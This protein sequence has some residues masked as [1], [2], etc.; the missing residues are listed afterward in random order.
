MAICDAKY[1]FTLVDVEACGRQSDGGIFKRSAMGKKFEKKSMNVPDSDILGNEFLPYVLVADEAFEMN[2]FTMRPYSR[3]T[4]NNERRIFNY[5]LSRARRVIESTFGIMVSTWRILKKSIEH[6]PVN[7]IHMVKSIV[8]L[9]NWLQIFK[10]NSTT[11]DYECI[12]SFT[13]ECTDK[14]N[15]SNHSTRYARAV[16]DKFCKYFNNESSVMWQNNVL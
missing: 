14:T 7:V 11:K 1:K 16:R 8:C 6:D 3:I 12:H 9:H 15:K 5:R 2:D 10:D 4:L 13:D